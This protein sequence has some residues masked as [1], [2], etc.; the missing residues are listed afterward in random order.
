MKT[1]TQKGSPVKHIR[2]KWVVN[3]RTRVKESEKKYKRE[4]KVEVYE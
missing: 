3:P 1:K 2:K 4:K